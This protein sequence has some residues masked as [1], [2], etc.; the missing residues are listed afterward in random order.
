MKKQ[1]LE[2]GQI[3][4]THG[5]KGEVKVMPW[6]DSPEFLCAFKK[7]YLKNGDTVDVTNARVQKN[8]VILKIKGV[9]SIEQADVMRNTIL[10]MNR[11]DIELDED[12]FFWQDILNCTVIDADTGK[13]YGKITD[14]LETGANDVYQITDKDGKNY[15]I[16]VIDDVV[17]STDIDSEIVTI[18]PLKGIFDDED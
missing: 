18:R 6:C 4:N 3:V 14:I 17:V 9:N 2:I 16:P 1:F 5:L 13:E 12:V 10:Y 11:S 8:M 7:L 15:L